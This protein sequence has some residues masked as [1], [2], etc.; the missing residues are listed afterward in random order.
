MTAAEIGSLVMGGLAL[1]AAATAWLKARTAVK[2]AAAT[3]SKLA[4]H[5]ATPLPGQAKPHIP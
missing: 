5:A 2:A 1:M 4:D 3:A